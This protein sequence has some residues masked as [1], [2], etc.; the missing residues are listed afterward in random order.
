VSEGVEAAAR[1]AGGC[2]E[3]AEQLRE[4]LRADRPAELVTEQE[5]AVVVRVAGTATSRAG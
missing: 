2:P 3:L 4:T 1:D 5:V